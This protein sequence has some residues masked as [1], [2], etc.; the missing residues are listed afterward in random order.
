ME[1]CFFF[2]FLIKIQAIG[3]FE[4]FHKNCCIKPEDKTP[5]QGYEV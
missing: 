1:K 2:Y 3:K 4:F 5:N